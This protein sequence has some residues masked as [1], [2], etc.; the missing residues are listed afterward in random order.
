ML[1]M[2]GRSRTDDKL[3][4][5]LRSSALST[6]LTCELS[7]FELQTDYMKRCLMFL[8]PGMENAS[9]AEPTDAGKLQ[10]SSQHNEELSCN[11]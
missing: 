5:C 4:G 3:T 6:W 11:L 8:C 1:D 2:Q 10:Q 7:F 9:T